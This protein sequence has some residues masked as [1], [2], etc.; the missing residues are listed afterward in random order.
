MRPLLVLAP[1]LALLAG[2]DRGDHPEAFIKPYAGGGYEKISIFPDAPESSGY[3]FAEGIWTIDGD[4]K[5]ATP[6]N[7]SK[8]ECWRQDGAC[9]DYRANLMNVGG[10]V[11][12]NQDRDRYVIRSWTNEQIVAVAEGECRTLELRIDPVAE[13]VMSVATNNPGQTNCAQ[14][15]GLLPK[16]RIS[17]LIATKEHEEIKKA[18]GF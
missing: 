5:I 2:C 10:T 4:D 9:T 7:V 14:A 1:A 16:P 8:I 3:L 17:R 12:L 15:T 11:F 6:I 13:T 18:G